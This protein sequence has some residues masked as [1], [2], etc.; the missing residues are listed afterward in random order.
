MNQEEG[1]SCIQPHTVS[2]M[3]TRVCRRDQTALHLLPSRPSMRFSVLAVKGRN[4][5]QG[6]ELPELS[7]GFG[8]PF[9]DP[10][11][12]QTSWI[13]RSWGSLTKTPMVLW[14]S[15]R[16]QGQKDVGRPLPSPQVEVEIGM[17]LIGFMQVYMTQWRLSGEHGVW[18]MAATTF[19]LDLLLGMGSAGVLV[20][21]NWDQPLPN[22]PDKWADLGV[23][24]ESLYIHPIPQPH[25]ERGEVPLHLAHPNPKILISLNVSSPFTHA[26]ALSS[27]FLNLSGTDIWGPLIV[28]CRGLGCMLGTFSNSAGLSRQLPWAPVASSR[29][30]QT[31]HGCCTVPPGGRPP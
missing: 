19:P 2:C 22:T 14:L 26:S 24:S 6:S 13:V 5:S 16:L 21:L 3:G 11:S 30:S 20:E 4:S 12:W 31:F 1:P 18:L 8:L 10:W 29:S 23:S 27:E 9:L 15:H 25:S 7:I 17:F 28:G